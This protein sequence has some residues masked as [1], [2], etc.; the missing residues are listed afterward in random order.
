[1][2]I[3]VTVKLMCQNNFFDFM[4]MCVSMTNKDFFEFELSFCNYMHDNLKVQ[5]NGPLSVLVLVYV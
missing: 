4:H 5:V 3:F 1:M 2:Y